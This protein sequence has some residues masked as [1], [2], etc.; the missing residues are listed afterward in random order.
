MTHFGNLFDSRPWHLL[1]PDYS[2]NVV[3]G[4]RGNISAANYVMAARASDG[5]VIMAYVPNARTITVDMSAIA[6]SA[7]D[8]WRFDPAT[9]DATYL[10]EFENSGAKQFASVS[11]NDWLLVIDNADAGFPPPGQTSGGPPPSNNP[12]LAD[13]G[14]PYAGEAG[15]TLVQ[16][17]GSASSDPD[18]DALTFTWNFGDGSS[19][20]GMMPTHTYATSGN[21][22]VSLVVNDGQVDSNPD[23]TS[24]AIS[25]PP[26]NAAPT[27]DPGGPYNG[28]PGQ[29]VPF[30]GS[31]SSDPNGDPLTYAWDFGDGS[32]ASGIAPTHTFAVA[33]TYDVMLTVNDGQVDSPAATT[34]ASIVDP[35]PP[36][37]NPPFADAGG[38]YAGEAGS[39]AVQ[40]DGSASGD[41]DGDVLT[42]AWD[43]GDGSSASGMMPTHTY[44]T[45]GNFPVSLVVNDGQADSDPDV[46]SAAISAPPMNVPPIADSGGPYNGQPGQAVIFDGSGSSDPNGNSLTY[47]W[48]FGDGSFGSGVAPTHTFVVESNY[49]VMLTVND[50]QFDSPAATTTASIVD[51][52]ARPPSGDDKKSSGGGAIG[53]GE[54]LLFGWTAF[55]I[56]RS[57]SK[58]KTSILRN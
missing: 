27:A 23:M 16:F 57:R 41:L 55:A 20:G 49:T 17:D 42:F 5:S 24:A 15:A 54:I 6:G 52:P 30:D 18:A 36:N 43:F 4:D 34:T 44:A 3:S 40:F 7:A 28:Q 1:Q 26:M 11:N 21:F 37:N 50:G 31:G 51:S 9:G 29:A 2:A 13:A 35:P 48:D 19:A 39:T 32:F 46:T 12:P 33:S 22:Q 56:R 53:L 10:G 38:P 47:A 58:R 14:G 25:A 8:A 45:A